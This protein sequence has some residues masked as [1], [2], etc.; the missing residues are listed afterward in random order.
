MNYWN[1]KEF[2]NKQEKIF[3]QEYFDRY[4]DIIKHHGEKLKNKYTVE[5]DGK[6]SDY[7]GRQLVER[8]NKEY[9]QFFEKMHEF[10][11]GEKDWLANNGML[12]G[13]HGKNKMNSPNID[14]DKF[15]R[16]LLESWRKGEDVT[17]KI[18]IDGLRQVARSMMIEMSG[19]NK[20]FQEILKSK[21]VSPTKRWG[22]TYD[23]YFPH[24]HFN[25]KLAGKG[26]KS[27]VE[28]ISNTPLSEFDPDPNVA[29]RMK[30]KQIESIIWKNHTLTGD[31]TLKDAEEWMN[32][33]EV[34]ESIATKKAKK[35]D[36]IN[37]FNDMAKAGSMNSRQS[38]IPGWSIDASAPE[39]YARSLVNTY[40]RQMAQIFSRSIIQQMYH[41]MLPKWGETQTNAW[42]KFMKLYVQ[43]AIGNPSIIPE[44]YMNDPNLKLRGTPYAWWSDSNVQ[45]KINNV[46]E[47]FGIKQSDLPKEMRGVDVQQLRHWSNLEAQFEMAALLAHPKS[48][49][50]NVFGGTMH[51]VES[52]GWKN[53]RN[54]RNIEWLKQNVNSKWNSM[55]DVSDFVV[56]SGVFPEYMLYEAGI[57]KEIQSG[58]NRQFI[59]DVAKKMG[60]NPEMAQTTLREIAKQYGVK[61]KVVQFAAKFMTVPERM[62]RRDAFMAHYIQA[63]ERYGGAI[64]DPEHPFLIEQAKKGVQA[65]QF[66]YSA[67]FR[68]GFAR[69]ALG[70]VMT[71]FQLWSWNAVRFRNEVYRQAKMYGLKPGTEAFDRYA[72]MMQIDIF[73][74][75][76]AN[77]FAYSLFETALPAP[78]NWMQD[79]A[80]WVFGNE[81]ERDRA[82]F[83]QWPKQ[84]APLQMVTPPI[85]RLLPS[86]MRALVDDDWSKFSEYYIWTMFPF[87][88]MA[89]DIAGPNNLVENPIRVMEKLT[90]FPLLNLQKEARDIINE[91]REV[92]TP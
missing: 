5:L 77:M 22:D 7:T 27:L 23:Y 86:S 69:T 8:I 78:W 75:A 63:W 47:Q 13:Y 49:V 14:N 12:K 43:D 62:I 80:D 31:W 57:S 48:M 25:K 84:L 45:K 10:I 83:G 82:F 68:P 44:S 39:A 76:L 50:T 2:L 34:Y 16:Y 28:K 61:E 89:R 55:Q 18:G 54:A 38:H 52:A 40:H 15:M 35:S 1:N 74:F 79:T 4:N 19:S 46:M 71:R 36:K 60:K 29:E 32:F 65:T 91:D 9:S 72:R 88:R 3:A 64:K 37:W 51:T 87:G 85:F 6:R 90:G 41:K 58:R 21:P 73:T 26:M 67:P 33:D 30:R 11:T 59:E 66:L 20:E 92:P 42:Q 70:K 24:M 56:R 53:W 81:K 17:T